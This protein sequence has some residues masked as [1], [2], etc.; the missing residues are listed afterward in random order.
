[1]RLPFTK[2]HGLGND[3][4]VIDCVSQPRALSAQQIAQLADRHLGIGFDQLLQIEPAQ[5][6]S[7]DFRY[8]IFNGDGSEVEHCGNGARCFAKYV[9]DKELTTNN[10][11][12]VE[13]VNRLLSLALTPTGEVTV[14]MGAP[15]F[16]PQSLPFSATTRAKIYCA[17]I[18]IDG[19]TQTLEFCALSM[20]NPHAVL[21]VDDVEATDVGGIGAALGAH[22]DFPRG[23]NVGFAQVNSRSELTLRVFE[24][25]AGETLACGTGACAAVAAARQLGLVDDT[26]EASLRGGKL[27]IT[28]H[29]DESSVLMTGSATTVYEGVVEI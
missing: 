3:F 15:D 24:R 28:W 29:G 17:E 4:A 14:D 12:R 19:Q 18:E 6:N 8:R 27:S 16:A 22:S 20:G 26:V 7:A 10:P 2:M 11:V 9:R 13:T 1:M 5:G 23:V 25:G 21:F